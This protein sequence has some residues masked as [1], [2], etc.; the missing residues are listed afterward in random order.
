ME[1]YQ[2]EIMPQAEDELFEIGYF[3]ALDSPKNSQKFIN[4]LVS[5]FKNTLSFSPEIGVIH[6]DNIRK[7]THKKH[8]AFYRINTSKKH[9]EILH[10][11]NLTK[12]LSKRGIEF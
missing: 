12:P 1:V 11:V 5:A 2:V 10:I 4:E 9:V 6:K 7:F 3:I 8:T